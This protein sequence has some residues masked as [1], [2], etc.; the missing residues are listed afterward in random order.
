MEVLSILLGVALIAACGAFVAAE[1]SL[2]TVN[3][4]D[5][6]AAAATGDRRSG[7]V[8]RAMKTLSTQLSGAQLGITVTNL[9][10]GFLAEP[11]IAALIVGPL[12]DAGLS[13]VAARST[14][15]VLALVL[16]TG[17]TMIFGELVPKN[18][19]ISKPLAT[20][21]AVSG[22]QR[23][24]T[25][26][27]AWPIRLFNGNANRIVRALGVEPQE[28]LAST[29]SPEELAG[30]VRHSAERGALAAA[31]AE[32]VE[33]SFAFG[34]RRAHD[35]MT[36]R[37]QMTTLA[38][39]ASVH[40]LLA[41]AKASGHSRF[42]VL[43][44]DE[45][46]VLGQVHVRHGLAVP[47]RERNAVTVG[48]VMDEVTFVPDT[49]ELDELMDTLRAGGL[50]M[51]VLIDE[52]GDTAGLV[53]LEDLVEELVGE[54]R[55][56]HDLEPE[57][58]TVEP[59][60]DEAAEHLGAAVPEHEDYETLAGLVTLHLGRLAE[61]GDRVTVAAAPAPG[62]PEATITFEVTALDVH[63]ITAVH[64]RVHR[65]GDG[66]APEDGAEDRAVEVPAHQK[67]SAR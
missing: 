4:N 53:T 47:Y 32:L 61:V 66:T 1:F 50:Q 34:D 42:P 19:A 10:I 28:E 18:L 39:D 55:D 59:R 7:G 52:F 26:A 15:I 27:L 56:E 30:L 36:P 40:E 3:R 46:A 44:A 12:T 25:R 38:P 45:G 17:L 63:R 67:E 51:A 58:V 57:P 2:I 16:A 48:A 33:R 31:T 13:P 22:F 49:V 21:R 60:P 11:A 43:D 23:G 6:E 62:E 37:G 29:R 14:S 65:P 5:V 24:F 9:G 8:L 20:A 64:A 54:V 35:V 41:A